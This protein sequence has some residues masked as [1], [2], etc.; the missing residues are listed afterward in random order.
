M[1]MSPQFYH[2]MPDDF[3]FVRFIWVFILLLMQHM[4]IK[5]GD[6]WTANFWAKFWQWES[7]TVKMTNRQIA[8]EHLN[9]WVFSSRTCMATVIGEIYWHQSAF[10]FM[11]ICNVPTHRNHLIM[12]L[13]H[14]YCSIELIPFGDSN[15]HTFKNSG[16]CTLW[17]EHVYKHAHD[18]L[19][20]LHV[21]YHF[22]LFFHPCYRCYDLCAIKTKLLWIPYNLPRFFYS[23]SSFS[24]DELPRTY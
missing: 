21:C 14:F 15:V 7:S 23:D 16:K 4:R 22:V 20:F 5:I 6:M 3:Y 24:R 1:S 9:Y 12:I 8:D 13:N 2:L 10:E 18:G 17:F 11:N 19:P